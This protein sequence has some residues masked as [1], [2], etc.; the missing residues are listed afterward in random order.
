MISISF[1]LSFY[2]PHQT[3]KKKRAAGVDR[4]NKRSHADTSCIFTSFQ[5]R[6]RAFRNK[7][8]SIMDVCILI[9][10]CTVVVCAL[11]I[12]FLYVIERLS[13]NLTSSK[14]NG[15]RQDGD[16]QSDRERIPRGRRQPVEQEE[17]HF[18]GMLVFFRVFPVNTV[19]VFLF[20]ILL[21]CWSA[22]GS[23]HLYPLGECWLGL[24]CRF[25][26]LVWSFFCL[27]LVKD[28]VLKD[29]APF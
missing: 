18:F 29:Q 15:N 8:H 1:N 3:I 2:F 4:K 11:Q 10:V 16:E 20:K 13:R 9:V 26:C 28:F 27:K 14:L 6:T 7:M 5:C 17:W 19:S 22:T 24:F 12:L 21:V 23:I 25:S